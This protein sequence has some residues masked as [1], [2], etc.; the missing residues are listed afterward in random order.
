M[1]DIFISYTSKDRTGH[2]GSRT[3][4]RRSDIRRI[5]T[6]GRFLPVAISRPGWRSG[7][8]TRTTAVVSAA[9]LTADYSGWECLSGPGSPG[10]ALPPGIVR[11]EVCSAH[12][13]Q[14]V[15]RPVEPLLH[16]GRVIAVAEISHS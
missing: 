16:P 6:S 8:T 4:S 2:S 14:Y 1:A 9:Y 12:D 15:V 3:N 11:R 7:S 5:F 10:L 13:A